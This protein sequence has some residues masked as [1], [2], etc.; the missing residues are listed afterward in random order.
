[1]TWTDDSAGAGKEIMSEVFGEWHRSSVQ[2]LKKKRDEGLETMH[3][4]VASAPGGHGQSNTF[5]YKEISRRK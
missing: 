1:M 4:T 5:F 2:V 3:V